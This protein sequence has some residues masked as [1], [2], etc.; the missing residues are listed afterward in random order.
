MMHSLSWSAEQPLKIAREYID[1]NLNYL[2]IN[3]IIAALYLAYRHTYRQMDQA[4]RSG[5][6][7]KARIVACPP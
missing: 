3:N 1:H 7:G 6:P 5:E 2:I 4:G